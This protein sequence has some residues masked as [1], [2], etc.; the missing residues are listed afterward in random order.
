MISELEKQDIFRLFAAGNTPDEVAEILNP[1]DEHSADNQPDPLPAAPAENIDIS[2][3]RELF[4]EYFAM[5]ISEKY[6]QTLMPEH[7]TNR[8]HR[9]MD[10]IAD[11]ERLN[12]SLKK[13][14]GKTIISLLEL[15]QKI[16]ERMANEG[17]LPTEENGSSES[18][19]ED[20]KKIID[21]CYNRVFKKS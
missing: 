14:R 13:A 16:K 15:K 3:I 6:R 10:D 8:M 21:E 1:P 12:V 17:A 11:L 9:L 4:N 19:E 2:D 20:T 7:V 18:S 5:T